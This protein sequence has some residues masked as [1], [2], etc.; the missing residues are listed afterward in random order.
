MEDGKPL[1]RPPR[2][3]PAGA[4]TLTQLQTSTPR[5]APQP[6]PRQPW[7][8]G[9]FLAG[10]VV[11]LLIL[12]AGASAG[13]YVRAE[14]LR[15]DTEKVLEAVRPGVVRVLA[16]TCEGTGEATGVLIGDNKILTAASAL[17]Q[18]LSIAIVTEDG[19]V[20]RANQLGSSADGVA[21]L[22]MIGRL[23]TETVPLAA[24][25]PDPKAERALIGY[26][27]AGQLTSR[28]VGTTA[29]PQ[30]LS[31]WMNQAKLG[32][33]IVDE[34]GQVVGLVTGDTVPTSTIVPLDKLQNYAAPKSVGLTPEAAGTCER[35]RGPQNAMLPELLVAATPLAVESQKVLGNYLTLEN[36]HDFPAVRQQVYSKAMARGYSESRDRDSHQTS[37]FF[38]AKIIEVTRFGADG[39]NVRMTYDVLFS[40]NAKGANGGTCNQLDVRYRLIREGGQLRLSGGKEVVPARTCDSD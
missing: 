40:P 19:R 28:S 12:A 21:V 4:A 9:R 30:A 15:L 11:V 14:S 25:N 8:F 22:Q 2:R 38:G 6:P 18:P 17:R 24:A 36:R 32:G 20:R 31:S 23:D 27:A 35:S 7:K 10:F 34:S 13:W 1:P 5:T 26:T 3:V 16:T 37:Y 29:R 39:A 33:P